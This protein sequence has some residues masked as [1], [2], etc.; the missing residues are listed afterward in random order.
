MKK[1]IKKSSILIIFL[2]LGVFL[3]PTNINAKDYSSDFI[4]I[5]DISYTHADE[6]LSLHEVYFS[7]NAFEFEGL[8]SYGTL[9]G[10]M[11]NFSN[12]YLSV[13]MTIDYYDSNYNIIARSTKTESP[14]DA[15][16][17]YMMNI[18][19]YD[20]DFLNDATVNDIAYFK[21]RYYTVKGNPLPSLNNNTSSN[22]STSINVSENESNSYDYILDS[23]NVDITVNENNTYDITETIG[24]YFNVSKHGIFRTIPLTNTV[25]R[26][27]GTESKNRAKIS[28]LKVNDNYTTS[29]E[30]DSYEI[31]IGS[32]DVVLTGPQKYEISYNYNIGKDKSENYDELYFNIIGYEWDTIIKNITFTIT[33][34]KDFD[35]SKL[36]FSAGDV[37]S[38]NSNQIQYSVAGNKITGKYNGLLTPGQALTVRLELPEGY[39][40]NA[41]YQVDLSTY[42]LFIVPA[43]C[44]FIVICLWYKFGKDEEV[45]ETVEFYP[46]EGFNSLEVGYLY[47]GNATSEDVTSLLLYL[48]NKGYIKINKTK[49]K[50]LFSTTNSFEIVKLK[51]Y[52]GNNNL[53]RDFLNGLFK[54]SSLSSLVEETSETTLSQ[55]LPTVTEDD[56]YDSFYKTMNKI[57]NKVNSKANKKKIFEPIVSSRTII[58]TLLIIVSL[59][60]IIAIPTLAY[61]GLEELG[62]T[63]FIALFYVPFYAVGLSKGIPK[64]FRILWLGFTM[65]HSFVFFTTMPVMTAIM[66]EV[67]FLI[68]FLLGI[69]DIVGMIICF[70]SMPKRTK[71][72]NEILGKI[73]GFK[74]FLETAEKENLEAMVMK[75]P[76]YFYN[77]LPFTYVLGVSKKWIDKFESINLQA[78]DWYYS[79]SGF[80]VNR[81]G[82]FMNN[83]MSS[84]QSAMSSSPS[85]SSGSSSSGGSSGGG[86]SGGGSGGGG[87][88]SW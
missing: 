55:N 82:T 42:L 37:G 45:I 61:A 15:S 19:L 86:S 57:L 78:P 88:G 66:E 85:S 77:I 13:Y 63:L 64:S 25:T 2:L 74:T 17:N 11:N 22:T 6:D 83:T 69:I 7:R 34:P 46:P 28:N 43:I 47:K 76:T 14:S 23:Y 21:I 1:F 31:K 49:Q 24:A 9:F 18:I 10:R 16:G 27:D 38:T 35:K 53:E 29:R 52:D 8:T 71:Y 20:K 56:L 84:A 62:T 72:G 40:V 36:G 32:A 51:D 60:T 30:N 67:V 44:L 3:Y 87:G 75:D 58:I 80:N 33:M 70:K 12:H 68:G 41:G 73:R 59:L 26:L 5:S 65:F 54:H 81:F 4:K 79:S 48:A 50:S 39:F